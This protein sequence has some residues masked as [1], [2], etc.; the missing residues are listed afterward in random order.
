M[1]FSTWLPLDAGAEVLEL[2]P[3]AGEA[4]RALYRS[5]WESGVDP[6]VLSACQAAIESAIGTLRTD[7]PHAADAATQAAVMFA[8]QYVVDAHGVTD[9]QAAAL[10]E[11]FTDAQL[12]ALTT[13]IA[14]F[15]AIARVRAVLAAEGGAPV[16]FTMEEP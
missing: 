12:A 5:L 1:T 10:H 14:T 7:P 2:L 16:T 11:H 8:E 3:G 4:L 6:A 15:D 13:A 9:A